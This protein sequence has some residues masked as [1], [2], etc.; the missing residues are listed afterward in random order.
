MPR[1][2]RYLALSVLASC[3]A[4]V[5][6]A[7]GADLAIGAD[8]SATLGLTLEVPAAIDAKI[9][10][11]A[12][13]EVAVAGQAAPLFN[14]RAV[15]ASVAARGVAV[16]TSVAPTAQSYSGTFYI[17]DLQTLLKDDPELAGLFEYSTE[18]GSASLRLRVGRHNAGSV[19]NLFP[20][21]DP[22]LLDALQ[23]P[24][25]YDNPVS[26]AEYRS[27]LAALLG[28]AAAAAIDGAAFT[29]TVHLPGAV[30]AAGDGVV[31]SAS[32]RVA[33]ITVPALEA[34]VL[35]RAVEFSVTW[36]R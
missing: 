31:V 8:S 16:R 3:V 21:I 10:S 22:E 25:L 6:C 30:L 33:S 14:A 4:I 27:M 13:P 20:G 12:S 19:V 26:P 23:P 29:M 2:S 24:A 32:R 11:F 17:K 34:M 18:P 5:S 7:A 15:S 1:S 35:D 9:R 36:K 28:K